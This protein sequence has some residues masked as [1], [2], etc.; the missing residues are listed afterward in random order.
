MTG[1]PTHTASK[2]RIAAEVMFSSE[3]TQLLTQSEVA[4]PLHF[5]LC[6]ARYTGLQM[7]SSRRSV[8]AINPFTTENTDDSRL[9]T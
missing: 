4:S 5:Q 9:Q 6:S 3:R 8:S 7:K 2:E 1:E